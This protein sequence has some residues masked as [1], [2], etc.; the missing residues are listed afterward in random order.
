VRISIAAA[1][2]VIGL[3]AT[4]IGAPRQSSPAP[5]QGGII[6]GRVMAADT[7]RPLG[8]AR[9]SLLPAA[10]P[11]PLMTTSTG[12]QGT[13][14]LGGVPAGSYYI[15]ASRAGYLELQYGQRRPAERGLSVAVRAGETVTR[16]EIA[17][18]RGSVLAGTIT[19]E[20][21]H[22]YPGVRVSAWQQRFHQGQRVPFPGG[23]ATTDDR[24]VFRISGLPPGRY[25]VSAFSPE[26]WLD[27]RNER[28]G[29]ATTYYPGTTSAGAQS[30]TLGLA[31]GR[32]TSTSR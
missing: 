10:S 19:D 11:R 14:E 7:G 3:A 4:L 13:F 15:A 23:G 32:S 27:E 26:A 30:I 5:D 18:P 21:G 16:I 25:Q 31:Q 2:A 9:V 12:S 20:Q 29:Y 8:R 28:L 1:G 22:G 17:L 6:R 24:G